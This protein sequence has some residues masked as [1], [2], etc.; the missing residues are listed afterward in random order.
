[1]NK[2][3][4]VKPD[5]WSRFPDE[6]IFKNMRLEECLTLLQNQLKGAGIEFVQK[7]PTVSIFHRHG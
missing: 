3:L 6:I 1:M 7:K 4:S 2:P 5:L